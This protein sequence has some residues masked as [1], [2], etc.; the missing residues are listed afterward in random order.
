M[1]ALMR[2]LPGKCVRSPARP[3]EVLRCDLETKSL[4]QLTK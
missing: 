4:D 2:L 3:P 1:I